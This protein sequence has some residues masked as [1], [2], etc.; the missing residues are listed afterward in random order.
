[1]CRLWCCRCV[2]K[3]AVEVLRCQIGRVRDF[4]PERRLSEG[5]DRLSE[6]LLSSG[7]DHAIRSGRSRWTGVEEHGA[8]GGVPPAAEIV[9]WLRGVEHGDDMFRIKGS[10]HSAFPVQSVRL[11]L[12]RDLD[13]DDGHHPG[14]LLRLVHRLHHGP[15]DRQLGPGEATDLT[16]PNL[17]VSHPNLRCG[18][19]LVPWP[20]HCTAGC[21]GRLGQHHRRG[22]PLS[23]CTVVGR[24]C[25][26]QGG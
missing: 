15:V 22:A 21:G 24:G 17:A 26:R 10:L 20:S 1:M 25:R 12:R 23:G 6:M 5:V 9:A 3:D 13:G 19:R 4:H 14:S 8:T 18:V 16:L 2:G 7:V 11:A